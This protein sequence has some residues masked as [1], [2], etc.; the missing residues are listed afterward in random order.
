[1]EQDYLVVVSL[2]VRPKYLSVFYKTF[3]VLPL[4]SC[5]DFYLASSD[6]VQIPGPP[7]P[8]GPPGSPGLPGLAGRPNVLSF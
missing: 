7:G 4:K 8:P 2:Q 5:L 1:M 6:V 3:N